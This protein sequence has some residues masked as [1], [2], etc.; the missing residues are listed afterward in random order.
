MHVQVCTNAIK[1]RFVSIYKYC[2]GYI[3]YIV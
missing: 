3:E 1:E 2:N